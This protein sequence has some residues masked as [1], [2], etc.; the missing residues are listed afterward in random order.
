MSKQKWNG[1]IT[2]KGQT[3]R[4]ELEV[5]VRELLLQLGHKAANSKG[6]KCIEAGGLVKVKVVQRLPLPA[7]PQAAHSKEQA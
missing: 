1:A 5:D 7:T 6:G 3:V 4:V 2:H